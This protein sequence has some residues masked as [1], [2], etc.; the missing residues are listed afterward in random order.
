ME[1]IK[2][3]LAKCD[4]FMVTPDKASDTYTLV[5]IQVL[6]NTWRTKGIL[7]KVSEIVVG[8]LIVFKILRRK[9]EGE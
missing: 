5:Q 1:N 7:I 3:V 2:I 4:P 6:L 9:V 8:N